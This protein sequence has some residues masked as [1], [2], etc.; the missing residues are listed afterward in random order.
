M[1]EDQTCE[2]TDVEVWRRNPG[3]YYSPSMHVTESGGI[4]MNVG[5]LVV[6]L[7]IEDWHGLAAD[8]AKPDKEK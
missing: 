1:T 4:G 3:D 2:N 8:V 6:V 5:G 7:P